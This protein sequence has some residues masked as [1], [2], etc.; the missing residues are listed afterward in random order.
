MSA[1][2]TIWRAKD[3]GWWRREWIVVLGEEFGAAGPAVIDWLECEAKAQNDG[4]TVKAGPNTAARGCFVDVVT[5]SHVLSRAV[6]L[7]LLVDYRESDG[8]FICRI[9]WWQGDQEKALAANRQARSRSRPPVNPDDPPPLSRP[10]TPSHVESR[11][12]T[13]RVKDSTESSATQKNSNAELRSA[14]ADVFTYWQNQC[15]HGQAQ[16]TA[17][18]QGKITARLRERARLH[19]GMRQAVA[20]IHL[21]IDGAARSPFVDESGKRHDDIELIC[22]KG[23]KLEDFMARASL[24]AA[25]AT[26]TPINR[27]PNAGDLIRKLR[28]NESEAS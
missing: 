12:V 11:S 2:R 26:V 28:E 23:S 13:N 19:G 17:D 25:G 7:G 6:T 3:V 1:G 9:A 10:V 18:R 8:R 22:R 21:G 4:G 14:V 24:P 16:F 15:G 5:V 27:R 20:D